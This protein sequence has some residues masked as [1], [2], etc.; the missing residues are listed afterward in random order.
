MYCCG[1]FFKLSPFISQNDKPLFLNEKKSMQRK[2][3]WKV[4]LGE[5]VRNSSF[6]IL[7]AFKHFHNS[8]SFFSFSEEQKEEIGACARAKREEEGAGGPQVPDAD[9]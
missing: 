6:I 7:Y 4:L 9:A 1:G 8:L 5:N 3:W 2:R